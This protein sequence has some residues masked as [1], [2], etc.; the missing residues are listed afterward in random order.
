MMSCHWSK[1][2]AKL[3]VSWWSFER[4]GRIDRPVEMDVMAPALQRR[5]IPIPRHVLGARFLK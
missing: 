2:S 1:L 4:H 5:L 3:Q